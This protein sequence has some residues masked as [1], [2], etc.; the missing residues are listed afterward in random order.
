MSKCFRA[1]NQIGPDWFLL[2]TLGFSLSCS[3][4][5][6]TSCLPVCRFV[7]WRTWASSAATTCPPFQRRRGPSSSW[8]RPRRICETWLSS[9]WRSTRGRPSSCLNEHSGCASS[10]PSCSTTALEP[11]VSTW[12][13]P[14]LVLL[15]FLTGRTDNHP[16]SSILSPFSV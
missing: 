14:R 7:C 15:L 4:L 8:S 3:G 6:F 1:V 16:S 12:T 2:K 5:T 11:Q 10:G 13:T 9:A